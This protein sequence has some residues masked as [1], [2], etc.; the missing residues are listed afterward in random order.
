MTPQCH[1]RRRYLKVI[2]RAYGYHVIQILISP[3]GSV[4]RIAHL[5]AAIT[6][7]RAG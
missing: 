6:A 2:P 3:A 1:R 5:T 4:W 7:P